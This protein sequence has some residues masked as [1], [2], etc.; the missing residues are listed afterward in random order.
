[1]NILFLCSRNRW[2]SLTAERLF[3]GYNGHHARSA[4]TEKNARVKVTGGQIGWAD[5]IFVMEKKH[6]QR[7]R[8]KYGDILC[9]KKVLV[10]NIPDE[11][12]Y[13]DEELIELLKSGVSEYLDV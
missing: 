9:G 10:L 3:D 7:I 11:Y 13:M 12:D 2:R 4:G 5:I 8:E 6:L 1:M